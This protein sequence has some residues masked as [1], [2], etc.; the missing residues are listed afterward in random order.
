MSSYSQILA[1]EVTERKILRIFDE[2]AE[3]FCGEK[4]YQTHYYSKQ[5]ISTCG[6]DLSTVFLKGSL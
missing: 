1:F 6:G 4:T 5:S 3:R 2:V